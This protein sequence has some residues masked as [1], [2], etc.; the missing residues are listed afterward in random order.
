MLGTKFSTQTQSM[1]LLCNLI[2]DPHY[3]DMSGDS[4]GFQRQTVLPS[5]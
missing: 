3:F 4:D 1:D 2:H 5:N